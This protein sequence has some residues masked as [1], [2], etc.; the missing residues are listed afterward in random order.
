LLA[1]AGHGLLWVAV[2]AWAATRGSL[3]D[4]LREE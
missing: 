3:V 4:A 2:A 1:V